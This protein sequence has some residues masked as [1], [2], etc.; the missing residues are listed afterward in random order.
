MKNYKMAVRINESGSPDFSSLVVSVRLAY[1]GRCE[2]VIGYPGLP[3]VVQEMET[4]D[5]VLY[6]TTED[7]TLEVRAVKLV[8]NQAEFLVT[9]VSP[10]IGLVAGLIDEDPNNSP[11][12]EHELK[13]IEQSIELLKNELPRSS[14]FVPEQLSLINRTLD[15]MQ[16]A[17]KRLG[18]KDWINYVAGTMTA[19]CISASFAPDVTKSLFKS[20]GNAFVWLFANAPVLLQW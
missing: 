3:N 19:M 7:G 14:V 5:A 4:G 13:R 16:S 11:F 18:R 2:V 15:E 9:Q 6:Q 10:Q 1:E 12:G 8:T 17:S 20:I